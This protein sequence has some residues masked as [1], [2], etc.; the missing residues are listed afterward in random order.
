MNVFV[1]KIAFSMLRVI[2]QVGEVVQSMVVKRIIINM[3]SAPW[4]VIGR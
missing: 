3:V 4:K 1:H 2:I